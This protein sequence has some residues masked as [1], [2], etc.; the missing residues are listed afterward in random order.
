MDRKK[1]GNIIFWITISALIVFALYTLYNKYKPQGV[2]QLPGQEQSQ[3]PLPESDEN[4]QDSE[5]EETAE[6]SMAPDFTLKDIVDKEVSLSD[7]RGRVVVLNF[8][9]TWCTY[10]RYEMPDLDKV[11]REFSEGEDAIVLTVNVNESLDTVKEYLDNNDFSLP[12]LMD[13]DG[14]V[15][16]LYGVDGYPMTFIINRDG[17]AYGYIPGMTDENTIK[18]VVNEIK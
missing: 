10:C 17:S 4:G 2:R 13:Y 12:V 18:N 15:A 3:S 16:S 9:A 6:A 14:R 1:L 5:P 11:N 8:W 7:Y